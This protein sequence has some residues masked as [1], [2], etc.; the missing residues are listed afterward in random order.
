VSAAPLLG[1]LLLEAAYR[2]PDKVA[3]VCEGARLTY[4]ELDARSNALANT[5]VQRGVQRGDRVMIFGNNSPE[6]VVS[7][8]AALKAAAVAVV[9]N[10]LTRAERL[11][12]LLHDCGAAAL[13]AEG[14]LAAAFSEPASRCRSLRACLV[15]GSR[16]ASLEAALREGARAQPPVQRC[17][18]ADLAALVY[19]S[20]STGEP[21]GVMLTHRNML[22]AAASIAAYLEIAEDEVILGALPLAFDYGLYQMILAFQAGA[23]LVLERSFAFPARVL[24]RMAAERV[25]GLPGV[26]TMF[27]TLAEMKT[28]A[29]HDLSAIRYV[30]STGAALHA[31]HIAMLKRLFPAARVYSMYGLTECKRCSYLPPQDLERKPG[32]VGIAIPNTELWIVDAQ[33]RRLGPG[34][35]GELVVR[36]ATVMRGYWGK[37]QDTA[38]RLRPGPLPGELVLYTGDYCRLDE[39]GYLYFVGRMDELI[40]S[41]GAKVSPKEVEDVLV[42]IAG[43]KEAAVIGVHDELLGEAIKAFVVPAHGAE[44]YEGEVRRTCQSRLEGFKVPKHIVFVAD[45]PRGETGK[46]NKAGLS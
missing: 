18:D 24:A 9:I 2:A 41:R 20:G 1:N 23:R 8:W 40:K 34:C 22:A 21:K 26:P 38:Q 14:A 29:Q 43:V 42:G 35:V 7:F 16:E 10:P 12:Y 27:A 37:P 44:L 36:G 30:T 46:I 19:T 17:I 39:D 25:T 4:A 15:Y 45:L 32:S 11:A 5:L 33:D 3:L 28:L 31:K 6:V 13:I